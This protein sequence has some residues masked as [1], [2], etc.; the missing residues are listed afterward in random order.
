MPA[1]P[2]KAPSNKHSEAEQESGD[3]EINARRIHVHFDEIPF[4]RGASRRVEHST[5]SS[6]PRRDARD[7][8]D[9]RVYE[10]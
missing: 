7:V 6:P 1:D 10:S 4:H 8:S 5:A 2:G 9:E 3:V